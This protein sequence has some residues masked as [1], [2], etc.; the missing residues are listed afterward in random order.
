MTIFER[1]TE[2]AE[3]VAKIDLQKVY[4][5]GYAKGVEEGGGGG[6]STNPTFTLAKYNDFYHTYE[7]V[8]YEFEEGMTW[9][10]WCASEYNPAD[11]GITDSDGAIYGHDIASINAHYDYVNGDRKIINGLQYYVSI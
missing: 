6:G 3:K 7:F 11:S 10:E 5:T 8:T 2:I 9:S 4:D 1:I